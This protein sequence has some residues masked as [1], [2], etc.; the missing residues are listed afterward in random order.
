MIRLRTSS[1]LLGLLVLAISGLSAQQGETEKAAGDKQRPLAQAPVP[2]QILS[3]K[4]IFVAYG[5]GETNLPPQVYSGGPDRTYNQFYVALSRWGNYQLVA[6]P[7]ECD[8]VFEVSFVDSYAGG[9]VFG[10]AVT[11]GTS[12]GVSSVSYFDPQLRLAIVDVKTHVLLWA[13]TEHVEV[14]RLQGNRDKNFDRAIAALVNQV[15]RLAGKP[16][17]T[18]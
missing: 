12:G 13:L 10:G 3:A 1:L 9:S 6:T 11:S 7:A 4:K 14:A 2:A 17:A 5:G 18:T 16:P 8:L 15:A